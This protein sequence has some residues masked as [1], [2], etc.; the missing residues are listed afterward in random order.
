M[1][2]KAVAVPLLLAALVRMSSMNA[3]AEP[4][5][6]PSP[7]TAPSAI[8]LATALRL[9]GA[10]AI[11]VQIARE[12]LKAA[13]AVAVSTLAQLLPWLSAGTT[14]RRHGALIQAKH[15]SNFRV[16]QPTE[17]AQSYDLLSAWRKRFKQVA[18][19]GERF[20]AHHVI[21]G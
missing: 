8:D 19:V 13:E 4:T 9:A 14:Y 15:L 20:L 12:R 11:D 7:A 2:A 18:Q 16:L 21:F 1:K 6:A 17:K 5:P 3:A 10:N